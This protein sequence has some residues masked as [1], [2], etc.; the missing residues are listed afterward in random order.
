MYRA[1]CRSIAAPVALSWNDAFCLSAAALLF[2]LAAPTFAW[3]AFGH[4]MV[5]EIAWQQLDARRGSRLSTRSAVIRDSPKTL[6][7]RCLTTWRRPTSRSR[8]IG[9]SSKRRLGPILLARRTTIGHRGTISTCRFSRWRAA[10]HFDLS[11]DYSTENETKTGNVAQA[12]KYCLPIIADPTRRQPNAKALA[13]SWL[14]HLV[15]DMHQPFTQQRL[16]ATT[17]RTA[18]KAAMRFRPFGPQPTHFR[19]IS[20]PAVA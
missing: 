9:Y 18:T 1:D 14:M 7:R 5:A 11:T 16:F 17:F 4:K 13:Y 12:T 2:V 8:I 3:N 15:G 10:R 20:R 6:K 19:T